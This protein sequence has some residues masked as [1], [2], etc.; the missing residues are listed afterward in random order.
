M[1]AKR[2]GSAAQGR[3][4][5]RAMEAI[6]RH[7]RFIVSTHVNPEGDALGSALGLASLI[8]RLGKEAIVVTDGGVPKAFEFMPRVAPVHSRLPAGYRPEVAMTVDVPVLDR[9]GSVAAAFKSAPLSVVVDHH[10]SNRWFGDV[11]WV[12]PKA[13][14]T[15]EMVYR[16][17]RA[18][19]VTPTREEARCLY[20]AI[21]T[22]TGSFKYQSTTP[23]VLRIAADLVSLGVSPLRT[24]QELYECHT[25]SDMKF[26][27]KILSSMRHARGGK[28]AWVE[29]PLAVLRAGRPGPE[30]MDELVNFPRAVRTAEVAFIL[31]Q[32]SPGGKIRASFRS[33]GRIDVNKIARLFG[34]GGHRAASGCSIDGTLAQARVKVLKA[35]GKALKGS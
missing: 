9:L 21:V 10:V 11:N 35:V 8:R 27:G 24:S 6:R 15:G 3:E 23:E 5:N 26:L 2:N 18:F 1:S 32:T 16:L 13:A 28:V 20:V 29:V 25:A 31:R 12:D 33:K 17:Y 22:D 4:L 19:K 34:G 14:A 30:I 7:R